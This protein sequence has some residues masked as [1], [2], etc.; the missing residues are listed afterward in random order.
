MRAIGAGLGRRK[1]GAWAGVIYLLTRPL[2]L[3]AAVADRIGVA[4]VRPSL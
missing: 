2:A 3:L 1:S 4:L